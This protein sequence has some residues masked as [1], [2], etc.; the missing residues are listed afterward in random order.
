ML[1]KYDNENDIDAFRAVIY[2]EHKN[3][4]LSIIAKF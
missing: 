3:P 4:I 1:K 2:V